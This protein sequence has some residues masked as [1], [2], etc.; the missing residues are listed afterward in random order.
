[1]G[2]AD[3]RIRTEAAAGIVSLIKTPINIDSGSESNLID[4][5]RVPLMVTAYH[6]VF[7]A[8]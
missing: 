5:L 1:M 4:Y 7:C 8:Q 3:G 6:K 2:S